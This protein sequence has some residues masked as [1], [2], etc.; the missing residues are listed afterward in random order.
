MDGPTE[1]GVI[2]PLG[3]STD[4]LSGKAK[5]IND[6]TYIVNKLL[7]A[8]EQ[9]SGYDAESITIPQW[10]EECLDGISIVIYT[11]TLETGMIQPSERTA[12]LD[13]KLTPSNKGQSDLFSKA[14]SSQFK[15]KDTSSIQAEKEKVS[16]FC[17][18][19]GF[20]TKSLY[21]EDMEDLYHSKIF[22][23]PNVNTQDLSR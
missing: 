7:D 13:V 16:D 19:L 14:Y 22:Y 23:I 1:S 5:E 21:M 6:R 11:T 8:V 15:M 12:V 10:Y 2:V 18:I 9:G 20:N 4:S 17:S 3:G